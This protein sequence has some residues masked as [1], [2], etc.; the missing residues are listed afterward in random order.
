MKAPKEISDQEINRLL[1][2][3][4]LQQE[5]TALLEAEAKRV[6]AAEA[7]VVPSTEKEIELVKKLV[8]AKGIK[9][10][11]NWFILLSGIIL[12]GVAFLYMH[13]TGIDSNRVVENKTNHPFSTEQ[14][15]HEPVSKEI[16]KRKEEKLT[17]NKN[18]GKSTGFHEGQLIETILK[19]NADCVNPIL[20][21]DTVVFSPHTPIGSGNEREILNNDPSDEQYFENEHNTVWYKFWALQDCFL[22]FDIIPVD[23]NDDYDFML[24]RYNGG[25]FRAKVLTKQLRPIRTCIS[26]NDKGIESKTGLSM[27]EPT[28]L[29]VHSG[30]GPSYV[31]YIAVKKGEAYYLLVDNVYD[32]GKGH[33]IRFHYQCYGP[34]ELYVGK[35]MDLNN[36]SFRSDSA[37]FAP[38]SEKGLDSLYQFIK[39]NHTLKIEIRG[40]VNT[41]LIISPRRYTPVKLSVLR[42]QAIY[43]YLV[44]R[45]IQPERLTCV[46]YSDWQKKVKLPKLMKEYLMNMRSDILILSLDYQ[47]DLQWEKE[48]GKQGKAPH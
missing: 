2:A 31:K 38:G 30:V 46:G 6:F 1:K 10:Y 15:I 29:F 20:I 40:H 43:K 17:K 44:E 47:K 48:H 26:R 42:A 19:E 39:K 16:I 24:F 12:T 27:N 34:D 23:K 14:V 45:G 4:L 21:K 28:K 3:R 8:Q 33:T 13:Q 5:D 11:F 41:A 22:T 25:D 9:K 32:H 36:I 37:E 18:A 7:R 35:L